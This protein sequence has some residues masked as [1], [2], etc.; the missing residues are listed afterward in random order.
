M[1]NRP[2]KILMV[3]KANKKK[4]MKLTPNDIVRKRFK[5][6]IPQKNI[7]YISFLSKNRSRNQY[8]NFKELFICAYI[9]PYMESIDIK[10]MTK[11]SKKCQIYIDSNKIHFK[12]FGNPPQ[13]IIMRLFKRFK[14]LKEL[15]IE[16][17]ATVKINKDFLN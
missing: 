17:R 5:D 12:I 11:I 9:L 10:Q 15:Y 13:S 3:S 6:I 8:C 14:N 16:P 2:Q 4:Q 7:Q 1:K